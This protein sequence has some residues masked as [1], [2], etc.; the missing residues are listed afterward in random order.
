MAFKVG[1]RFG[2]SKFGQR[3]HVGIEF[4][5]GLVLGSW[6]W[7]DRNLGK[8]QEVKIRAMALG[9]YELGL[10]GIQEGFWKWPQNWAWVVENNQILLSNH[11]SSGIKNDKISL[12]T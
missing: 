6:V 1:I 11:N 10:N 12:V 8:L 7:N 4:R 9:W 2:T 5:L 3:F